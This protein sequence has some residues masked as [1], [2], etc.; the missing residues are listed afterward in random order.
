MDNVSRQS[1]KNRILK[2]L[3]RICMNTMPPPVYIDSPHCYDKEVVSVEL[4]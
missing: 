3:Y 2:I 4:I 1:K